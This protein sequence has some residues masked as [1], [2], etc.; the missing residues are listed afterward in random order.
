MKKSEKKPL[1]QIFSLPFGRALRNSAMVL[2][3]DSKREKLAYARYVA[4][5]IARQRKSR[6]VTIDD[7]QENLLKNNMDLGMAAGSVFKTQS[8]EFTGQYVQTK[9]A[10]SHARHVKVWRLK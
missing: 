5:G 6:L 1:N 2:A 10:S 8:W 9:R 4:E 7:V 3:A